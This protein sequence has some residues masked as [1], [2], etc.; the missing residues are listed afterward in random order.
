[1][2]VILHLCCSQLSLYLYVTRQMVVVV[3]LTYW[4]DVVGIQHNLMYHLN[5]YL[6]L[7]ATFVVLLGWVLH[8][9]TLLVVEVNL[10]VP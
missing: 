1:M 2:F 7:Y 5:A 4:F 8:L 6:V 10:V 9:I 3:V